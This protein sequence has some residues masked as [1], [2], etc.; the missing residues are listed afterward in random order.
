MRAHATRRPAAPDRAE[1]SSIVES[2][3]NTLDG[4]LKAGDLVLYAEIEQLARFI[5]R[6]RSEIA[7]IRPDAVRA[8]HIPTATDEL[9]AIVAATEQATN[10]IMASAEVIEGV[11]ASLPDE[12]GAKLVD[13]VTAIYEACGFQDITGQRIS[14]VVRTLKHIETTFDRITGTFGDGAS[15]G[16]PADG[17]SDAPADA[18]PDKKLL[19]GPQLPTNA[20]TQDDIDALFADGR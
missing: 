1:I 5:E 20:A 13:A 14:K 16:A 3:V 9:D 2:V 19:N 15:S 6:A 4:D 11:A 12:T 18:D 10:A 17:P 8:Q 7:A